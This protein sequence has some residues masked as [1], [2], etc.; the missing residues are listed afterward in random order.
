M[1]DNLKRIKQVRSVLRI[2]SKGIFGANWHRVPRRHAHHTQLHIKR[3]V[4]F[5]VPPHL[6]LIP[7]NTPCV[8]MCVCISLPRARSTWSYLKL[9]ERIFF[10]SL[11]L[12]SSATRRSSVAAAVGKRERNAAAVSQHPAAAAAAAALPAAAKWCCGEE[13]RNKNWYKGEN[14]LPCHKR[15][16]LASLCCVRV[17]YT[18][19][20]G[21]LACV[22][23]C[24]RGGEAYLPDGV[25]HAVNRAPW[26]P[27]QPLLCA[28]TVC[29]LRG[30]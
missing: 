18:C 15:G 21:S 13:K 8:Y 17:V 24:A 2:Y 11:S 7:A 12:S 29:I 16:A 4:R 23:V 10:L 9:K 26:T 3:R 5:L 1:N 30:V 19:V 14:I 22:G 20:R 28:A 6:H 25:R 27:P